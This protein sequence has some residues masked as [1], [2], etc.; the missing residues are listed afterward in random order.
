MVAAGANK[1]EIMYGIF[2]VKT[3]A[4]NIVIFIYFCFLMNNCQRPLTVLISSCG[5]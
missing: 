5:A 2:S 4:E 3:K 1:Q